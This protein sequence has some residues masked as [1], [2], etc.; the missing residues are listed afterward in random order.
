MV[1]FSVKTSSQD[2]KSNR[3]G[4]DEISPF[5]FLWLILTLI[6]LES[7]VYAV[8]ANDKK[9]LS[10]KRTQRSEKSIHQHQHRR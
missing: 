1:E 2:T 7:R 10:R 4:N 6:R 8:R 3:S 5:Q 9:T